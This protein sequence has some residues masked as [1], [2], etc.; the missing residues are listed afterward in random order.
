MLYFFRHRATVVHQHH[1]PSFSY[2]MGQSLTRHLASFISGYGVG[3]VYHSSTERPEALSNYFDVPTNPISYP[4]PGRS[5]A[6]QWKHLQL[7][8]RLQPTLGGTRSS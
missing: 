5:F 7:P 2:P 1:K 8:L 3:E 6:I 4:S